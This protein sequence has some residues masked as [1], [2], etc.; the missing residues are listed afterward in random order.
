AFSQERSKQVL[1]TPPKKIGPGGLAYPFAADLAA[2]AVMYHRTS[3]RVLWGLYQSAQT[4]LEPLYDELV[5]AVAA[6]DRGLLRDGASFSVL[7]FHPDSVEAGERQVVGVVKN[8]LVD[9]AAQRGLHLRVDA[10]RPDLIFHV[11][12]TKDDQEQGSLIVSLDL[13]GRPMHERGYRTQSG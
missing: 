1:E 7:A 6:D 9:G 13:A 10:E 12:S 3:A 5:E 2:I 4:R 8:A 11:R